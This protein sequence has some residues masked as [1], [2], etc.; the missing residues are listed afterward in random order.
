M[1]NYNSEANNFGILAPDDL[2]GG[3][4]FVLGSLVLVGLLSPQLLLDVISQE[5]LNYKD[6]FEIMFQSHIYEN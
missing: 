3:E 6:K 5:V 2:K 1:R 4:L